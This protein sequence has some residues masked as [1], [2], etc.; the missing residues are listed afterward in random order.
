M[1]KDPPRIGGSSR[2]RG[3]GAV[4]AK[5]DPRS[6]VTGARK[7]NPPR[8]VGPQAALPDASASTGTPPS[9][10][11]A[12]RAR[13]SRSKSVRGPV[14]NAAGAS[15]PTWEQMDVMRHA[16]PPV[17]DRRSGM[18]QQR[19]CRPLHG[20]PCCASRRWPAAACST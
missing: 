17:S 11:R 1:E 2:V 13:D 15:V 16:S 12:R 18:L 5:P 14:R 19:A 6:Y 9:V 8:S 20:S 7:T 4:L 3:T 10:A